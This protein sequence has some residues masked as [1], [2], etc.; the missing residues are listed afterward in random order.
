MPR[1]HFD[2]ELEQLTEKITEMG[3]AIHTSIASTIRAL[4]T[5]DVQLARR[6]VAGDNDVDRMEHENEKTCMN[7]IVSQQPIAGDLRNIAGSLK[8]LTDMEREADQCADICEMVAAGGLPGSQSLPLCHIV[9]TLEKVETM[10]TG[11]MDVFLSRDAKRAKEICMADDEID[12]L[13]SKI[14][15]EVCSSITQD[16]ANVM[17]EVDL[18]FIIKYVER[19]GDHATN[20]AE[21]VLYMVTGEHEDLNEGEETFP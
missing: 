12:S 17:R 21:W 2:H 14:V 16:S 10:F 5:G 1:K 6:V 4:R 9:N 19:M 18:L 7:L 11:A 3:D 13:F 8:I 15:L 20:I